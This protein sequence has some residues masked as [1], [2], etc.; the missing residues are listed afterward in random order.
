VKEAL[1]E[2]S[3]SVFRNFKRMRQ[4][5]TWAW[6][7]AQVAQTIELWNRSSI[8]RPEDGQRYSPT[9]QQRREKAYD[10]AL[11]AV[12]REIKQAPRTKAERIETQNRIVAAFARFSATALDLEQD[13]IELL[14][15]DFLPVGTKLARVAR[16]FEGLSMADIIQACRNAWTACGLQP[17]LGTAV[18]LTPSIT[19]YSLLYP[20]SDN[21][22]DQDGV[23]NDEKLRF[24]ERFRRL[25]QGEELALANRRERALQLLIAMIDG[26]YP[27]VRYPQ[28]FES[29][30][31]IHRAQEQSVEQPGIGGYSSNIEV[32]Q[33]SCAKGG[34]SVVADASLVH[35]WLDERESR[36]AF[37]WGVLLQLGDDLQDMRED[38]KRGSMTLFSRGATLNKPLDSLVVQLLSFGEE[39]GARMDG[40]PNGD[41][42]LKALLKMSWRSL[43]ITAIAHSHEFFSSGFLAEAERCSPFRFEFL[44]AQQE[45]LASR[46]G[47]YTMLF[48]AFL[49]AREGDDDEPQLGHVKRTHAKALQISPLE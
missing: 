24:S 46:Q 9:E 34:S 1:R 22:L 11:Q 3:F 38:M 26:Q 19:G 39:V 6:V 10:E 49:E 33:R 16:R 48:D 12:E 27:R 31:A 28:V 30:L 35:G 14:T 45:R 18:Q 41:E 4:I 20:Y 43:I 13:A 7:E 36:F 32:L 5:Y 15:D 25:L 17:L 44:R 42:T 29:L 23:P 40:L 8:R 37:E 47:L 21:Y 2:Q